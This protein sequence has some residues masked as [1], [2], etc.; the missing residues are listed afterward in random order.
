L[1]ARIALVSTRRA[2]GLDEDEAPLVMALRA[3]GAQVEVADWDNPDVRWS[4]YDLAVLRS[5]W[6]YTER[7]SEFLAWVDRVAAITALS[8]SAAVVR[9]NTDKHYLAELARAGVPIVPSRFIEPG[10]EA[11]AA[12]GIFLSEHGESELV[13]KPAVGAG[14]RDARRYG[15][16]AR[17][18]AATHADQLL[19][20]GR[21]VLL[22]PYLDRV[23]EQ[24]ETALIF[25]AGRFEHAIRKGPML[26]RPWDESSG[27][28]VGGES[29]LF[30][31]ERVVPRTAGTDELAVAVQA[32][33]AVP[34]EGLLYARVDLIRDSAGSPVLLELELTEPSLFFAHAPGSV[35]RF[36]HAILDHARSFAL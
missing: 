34:H 9:W 3:C 29:S 21:S 10:E 28:P 25:I 18:A 14:S 20:A 33:A 1:S 4:A 13:V 11:A 27:P 7:P 22:Q 15:R 26:P 16:G 24:G 6:D 2:R 31:A 36:G 35:E 30:V 19:Q 23:D 32:L 5:T 8:N 12:L 17:A